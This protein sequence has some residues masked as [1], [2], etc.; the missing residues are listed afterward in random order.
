MKLLLG[1][2]LVLLIC[3][4]TVAAVLSAMMFDWVLTGYAFVC[5]FACGYAL[6]CVWEV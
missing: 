2:F 5:L 1:L 6:H 4:G 3:V